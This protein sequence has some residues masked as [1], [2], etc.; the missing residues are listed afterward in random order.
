MRARNDG[1]LVGQVGHKGPEKSIID[2]SG[3]FLVEAAPGGES[4][5]ASASSDCHPH[6]LRKALGQRH[7]LRDGAN[8]E[9]E[10]FNMFKYWIKF[11]KL[12]LNKIQILDA[13][14]MSIPILLYENGRNFENKYYL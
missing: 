2:S 4:E 13:Q 7:Y 3:E 14:I 5:E 11:G 8:W 10:I 9:M 1:Y 6:H 12:F